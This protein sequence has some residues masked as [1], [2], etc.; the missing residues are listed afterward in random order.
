MQQPFLGPLMQ[1][2]TV[3]VIMQLITWSLQMYTNS[4]VFFTGFK[5]YADMQS[6]FD[7]R[8]GCSA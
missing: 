1:I 8:L 4:S 3:A 7:L 6:K 5:S 2:R